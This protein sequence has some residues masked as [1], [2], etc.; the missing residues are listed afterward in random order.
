[1]RRAADVLTAR[2]SH[3]E[4]LLREAPQYPR[5][6]GV[7]QPEEP[8]GLRVR[9]AEARHLF[10]LRPDSSNSGLPQKIGHTVATACFPRV[11]EHRPQHTP[12]LPLLLRF[13]DPNT[14]HDLRDTVGAA[15]QRKRALLHCGA[16]DGSLKQHDAVFRGHLDGCSLEPRIR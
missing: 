14:V 6:R 1:M 3:Q 2:G 16:A 15:C 12:P 11:V 5:S 8:A 9:H 13:A 4:P 7:G 10:E